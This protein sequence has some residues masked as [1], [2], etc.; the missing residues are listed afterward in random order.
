[1]LVKAGIVAVVVRLCDVVV[2]KGIHGGMLVCGIGCVSVGCA[3]PSVEVGDCGRIEASE[4][5]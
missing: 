4:E 3:C 2:R 1:M 5:R